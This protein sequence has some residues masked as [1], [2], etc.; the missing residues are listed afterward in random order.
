MADSVTK[1]LAKFSPIG[2]LFTLGSF[3]VKITETAQTIGL[4]FSTVKAVH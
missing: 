2:R 3:F 4:L 1:N